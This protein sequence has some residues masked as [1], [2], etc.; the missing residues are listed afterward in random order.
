MSRRV[1]ILGLTACLFVAAGASRSGAAWQMASDLFSPS[2]ETEPVVVA[3]LEDPQQADNSAVVVA[4][5]SLPLPARVA[6]MRTLPKQE[7]AMVLV[8]MEPDVA[9]ETAMALA[10]NPDQPASP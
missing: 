10:A 5:T 2:P 6:A 1:S 8:S 3:A 4:L 7:L 9:E